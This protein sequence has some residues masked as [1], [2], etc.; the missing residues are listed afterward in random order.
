MNFISGFK[1]TGNRQR[2]IWYF[3]AWWLVMV[4]AYLIV[5]T[6]VGR[7]EK[8]ITESGVLMA[9]EFSDQVNLP[10]LEQ[11]IQVMS[12]LLTDITNHPDVVYAAIINHQDCII[13]Y[14]NS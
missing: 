9:Q 14:T 1:V 7:I 13:A 8:E 11:N 2:L 4:I 5:T 10:L 3:L 12:E 6:L